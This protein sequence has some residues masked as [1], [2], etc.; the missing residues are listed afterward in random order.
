[1]NAI[2][3]FYF[4]L[5]FLAPVF[6]VASEGLSYH[7]G[8]GYRRAAN[9]G[10]AIYG[11]TLV[12][13]EVMVTNGL[14]TDEDGDYED[15]VEIFNGTG[16]T[17]DLSGYALTD[18]RT[19]AI[20]W[21]FPAKTLFPGQYITVWASAKDRKT[22]SLHTNFK[23][24][25]DNEKVYLSTAGGMLIDSV[26][27]AN[28]RRD[29][30]WGRLPDGGTQ[31][32]YMTNVT[33][34]SSNKAPGYTTLLEE[35]TASH[36]DGFYTSQINLNFNSADQGVQIRY[37]ND[38]SDPT[39]ASTLYQQPINIAG[40]IG[41]PN[42]FSM[43][44]TN[45]NPDP[46]PP[47][48]EGWQPPAGE[49]F[50]IHTLKA[51]AFREDAPPGPV[52]TYTYVI[53]PEGAERYSLPVVSISTD[54]DHLFDPET[55]IYVPGNHNNFKQEWE[56]PAHI[57]LFE[58]SGMPAFKDNVAIEIN[59][60]T[61]ASRPRKSLR[62]SYKD[63]IGRKWLDYQLFRDKS[64][65][66]Y[67]QFIL[68]NS[69]NDWDFTVFRDGLFHSL[70]KGLNIETQYYRPSVLFINGE[71]WGIHNIRDKYNDHYLQA[72]YGFDEQE[73]CVGSNAGEFKWGSETGLS[74]FKT[75]TDY[76]R[77]N[78]LQN[79]AQYNQVVERMDVNSFIDF[80][81]AN[82][83]VKNT[84]WP[85]NNTLYWRY[86]RNG[87]DPA[88]GVRDGRWRWMLLDTDFGFDLPFYYVQGLSEGSSHNTLA[89]ALA[90][91]GP[92]WPNPSWSTLFFRKL[93]ENA[94]FKKS[95][96]NRYCDLLNTRYKS[97]FVLSVIDSFA[98][99][100]TP[101]MDEHAARW[102]RP[103]SKSQWL[104]N[105]QALKS[106]GAQRTSAEFQHMK[107]TLGLGQLNDLTLDV[108]DQ[109]HGYI[110]INTIN[111]L[112]TTL[113]VSRN[114]YPWTGKYFATYPLQVEAVPA[115]GY[116]FSHWTGLSVSTFSKISV[117]LN[118]AGMLTA[119]FEKLSS[120]AESEEKSPIIVCPNPANDEVS[121]TGVELSVL[122]SVQI[123]DLQGRILY[124]YPAS[125]V[126][127]L[128]GL[129]P[130]MYILLI[131]YRDGKS[132]KK[133]LIRRY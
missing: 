132:V 130:G 45:D 101:E 119:H 41:E 38:G 5:W 81:I 64:T 88:A 92:A 79:P 32:K 57:T 77:N 122:S 104:T 19:L 76:I 70:A 118:S 62:V 17:V 89:F 26:P 83:Y 112:P 74:H 127:S 86:I 44:P 96:T 43:I 25:Q 31:W 42:V 27:S 90:P 93:M 54:P 67:K 133:K 47:F 78:N 103:E 109:N 60:N 106:F 125:T 6:C 11:G 131:H 12:I 63:H 23:I 13:N 124:S 34:G 116:R 33:P 53:D 87:F 30:S 48:Y 82:I 128:E 126:V 111:I 94:E 107:T 59:G 97:D 102:R 15:W 95:F 72:K 108:S 24:D 85:G 105:V 73:I 29:V 16:Q 65:G 9:F 68:R 80:Q 56:R 20:K 66:R 115:E 123:L 46:G 117:M 91:N 49:V 75:L 22:S 28:L 113:G 4:T 98:R 18:D 100:L 8:E 69:G 71:Y 61:T 3:F 120:V 110:K 1:M 39:Q 55:G 21:K 52:S 40:R 114:P 84:D 58:T 50:K 7:V 36:K 121:I 14:V 99:V 10:T 51:R 35:V 2:R 129:N 37:T